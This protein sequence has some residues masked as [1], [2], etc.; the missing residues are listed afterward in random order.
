MRIHM[1]GALHVLPV[2][3]V[4][5]LSAYCAVVLAV[6]KLAPCGL[7]ADLQRPQQKR[8]RIHGAPASRVAVCAILCP[9]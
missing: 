4:D 3:H 6:R 1:T 7:Q 8:Y 5:S 9:M 2:L